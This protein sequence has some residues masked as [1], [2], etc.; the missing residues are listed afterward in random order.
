VLVH[1]GRDRV[2]RMRTQLLGRILC[3]ALAARRVTSRRCAAGSRSN[4][5]HRLSAARTR[6]SEGVQ[7][8]S[9][10]EGVTTSARRREVCPIPNSNAPSADCVSR[11]PL[12]RGTG[13]R[14]NPASLH[15]RTV[16]LPG[17]TIPR[18]L[19]PPVCPEVDRDPTCSRRCNKASRPRAWSSPWSGTWKRRTYV[20]S[21]RRSRLTWDLRKVPPQPPVDV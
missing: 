4:V 5:D 6:D 17:L 20:S 19:I 13:N 2:L 21:S 7:P 8:V 1:D 12:P 15:P 3:V 16:S 18:Q 10:H 9:R 11:R 14:L